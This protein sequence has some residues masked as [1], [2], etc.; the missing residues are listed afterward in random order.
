MQFAVETSN[1]ALLAFLPV[2]KGQEIVW[3]IPL[4][5]NRIQLA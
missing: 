5:I 2:H 3:D 1:K 4:F